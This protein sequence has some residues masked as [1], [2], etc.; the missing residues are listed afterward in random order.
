MGLENLSA[1]ETQASQFL[2]PK[3]L[4]ITT[5]GLESVGK[6]VGEQGK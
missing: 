4:E 5:K 6:A 2:H 1:F 3:G